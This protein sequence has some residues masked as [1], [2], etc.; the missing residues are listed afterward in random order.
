M[1][2]DLKLYAEAY[3][4]GLLNEDQNASLEELER[5][6]LV[7]LQRPEQAQQ[8]EL[9]PEKFTQRQQELIPD[10]VGAAYVQ[11]SIALIGIIPYPEPGAETNVFDVVLRA[12][13][14]ALLTDILSV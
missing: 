14:S 9:E 6:G 2:I 7:T 5:R 8:Q 10:A 13:I 1:A 3:K 11:K 4:R 12:R